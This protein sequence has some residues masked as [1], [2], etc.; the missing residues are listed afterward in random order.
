MG[1]CCHYRGCIWKQINLKNNQ[2][3]KQIKPIKSK[4]D[5]KNKRL[6]ITFQDPDAKFD[7][8]ETKNAVN[9]ALKNVNTD[10]QISIFTKSIMNRNVIMTVMSS[11]TSNDLL[12]NKQH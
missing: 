10:V 3:R 5:N 2:L 4:Q 12:N 7:S 1:K 9:Q 11:Y 8:F 6:V